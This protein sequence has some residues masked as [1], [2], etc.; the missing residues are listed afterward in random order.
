MCMCVLCMC[1]EGW[2]VSACIPSTAGMLS[3]RKTDV[4]A[5]ARDTHWSEKDSSYPCTRGLQR[6]EKRG[7]SLEKR[8]EGEKVL[9]SNI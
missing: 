6:E 7:G 3:I 4:G 1:R 9:Y 8:V 2:H 5:E